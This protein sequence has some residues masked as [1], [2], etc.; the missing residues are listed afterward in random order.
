MMNDSVGKKI[1]NALKQHSGVEVELPTPDVAEVP[2]PQPAIQN[3]MPQNFVAAPVSEEEFDTPP[4][5]SVLKQLMSQLPPGITKHTGAQLIS[6]TMGALG[7]PIK[8]VL[9][10]AQEFQESLAALG[11][12]CKT[13][14]AEYKARI[15]DMEAQIKK[16]Q[17]QCNTL[18]DIIS[19]F[20]QIS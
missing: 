6:Q 3:F 15:A 17:K 13:N 10:E 12:E 20:V 11:E 8:S 2:A 14:I 1:V 19:L 18:N 16:I 5:V 7:I 4:N 9:Q